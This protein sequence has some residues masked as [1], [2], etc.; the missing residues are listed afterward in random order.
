[1]PP[2]PPP[3]IDPFTASGGVR[4]SHGSRPRRVRLFKRRV[5]LSGDNHKFDIYEHLKRMSDINAVFMATRRRGEPTPQ[6]YTPLSAEREGITALLL[7]HS[8]SRPLCSLNW[9]F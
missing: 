3:L 1:M 8:I 4:Y 7:M 9:L 2:P 6:S 5:I